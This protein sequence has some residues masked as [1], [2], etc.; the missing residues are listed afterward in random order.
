[1][2][3]KFHLQILSKRATAQQLKRLASGFNGEEIKA[4][5]DVKRGA[6]AAGCEWHS[7]A[8]DVLLKSGSD[9]EDLWGARV[10]IKNGA[11]IYKSQINEGRVG[12][13]GNELVDQEIRSEVET[14]LK[15]Y[16]V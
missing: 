11:I 9:S 10:N 13:D 12:S 15:Q 2:T 14:V 3:E 16:L 6:I 8:R 1:M 7:E 4:V 5:V